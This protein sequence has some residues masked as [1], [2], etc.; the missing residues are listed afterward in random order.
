MFSQKPEINLSYRK[1]SNNFWSKFGSLIFYCLTTWAISV[2]FADEGIVF[3]NLGS[4][5]CL[6]W[7][8]CK[9]CINLCLLYGE[10]FPSCLDIVG[11]GNSWRHSCCSGT[12]FSLP[13]CSKPEEK[14]CLN[15]QW[16]FWH[17]WYPSRAAKQVETRV[18]TLGSRAGA[19]YLASVHNTPFSNWD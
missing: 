17:S 1:W 8:H 13:L 15:A 14:H 6:V 9:H 7:E 4:K 5:P 11:S 16:T 18:L 19:F 10:A 2:E 3:T 12:C